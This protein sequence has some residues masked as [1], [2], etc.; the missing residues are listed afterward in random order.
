MDTNVMKQ[1]MTFGGEYFWLRSHTQGMYNS[2]KASYN[3]FEQYG[4]MG[5]GV[6]HK[7]NDTLYA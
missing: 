6:R 4:Y 5:V 2:I 7:M 1:R 3:F